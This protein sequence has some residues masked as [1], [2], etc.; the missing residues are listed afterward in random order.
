MAVATIDLSALNQNHSQEISRL[1]ERAFDKD[2]GGGCIC[3]LIHYGSEGS[4]SIFWYDYSEDKLFIQRTTTDTSPGR[5]VYIQALGSAPAAGQNLQGL[6]LRSRL[7]GTGSIA[8]GCD[9][10]EIKSGWNSNDDTGTMAG[11]RAVIANIDAK[12]GTITSAHLVEAQVDV[13]AGGTITTLKGFRASMNNSGTITTSY[14]FIVETANVSYNWD[15]GFYMG[16]SMADVGVY[17]GTC[18]TGIQLAG[19]QTTGI[20]MAG[21][22]T[23]IVIAGATTGITIAATTRL[24]TLTHT[25]SGVAALSGISMTTTDTATQTSGT[26]CGINMTY[27]Q[28]GTKTSS[29]AVCPILINQFINANVPSSFGIYHYL[30]FSGDETVANVNA[31]TAYWGDVGAN[32]TNVCM[33][34]LGYNTSHATGGRNCFIRC[35]QHTTVQSG[36]A[37]LRLEGNG[38]A[39]YL[40]S[41]E[42][43]P[44]LGQGIL[45]AADY[46]ANTADHVIK[47]QT[48][49]GDRWIQLYQGS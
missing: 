20:T 5:V 22:T 6:Q 18:T 29:G 11:S 42:A 25:L 41:F 46:D 44:D 14:A 1:M 2:N 43:Q 16:T 3:D 7:T 26:C 32:V 36:S 10:V 40:V 33:I 17:L 4:T 24:A 37:V 34:D 23:G 19:T 47:V 30:E 8:G 27:N 35:R 9:G 21:A 38:S 28:N 39:E 31:F 48:P 12:K 45:T 13:G 15:Y 49:A